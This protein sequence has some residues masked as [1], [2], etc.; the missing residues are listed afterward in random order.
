MSV[1]RP[2]PGPLRWLAYTYGAGL[3]ARYRGWVF[4]DV[5]GPTWIVRHF[6]RATIY[7]APIVIAAALFLPLPA[8]VRVA[9]LVGSMALG[10][11]FS[12][13]YI[14][15]ATER[16]MEKAGFAPGLAERTRRDRSEAKHAATVAKFRARRS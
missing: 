15:E 2:R 1:E 13:A 6:L 14:V 12:A 10:Y 11:I 3:P 5:T 7:M 4:H 8:V 9:S 16:R